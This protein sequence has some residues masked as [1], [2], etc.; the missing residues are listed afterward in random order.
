M[1]F[2]RLEGD[3]GDEVDSE[4]WTNTGCVVTNKGIIIRHVPGLCL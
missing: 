4:G 3:L 2:P 1:L